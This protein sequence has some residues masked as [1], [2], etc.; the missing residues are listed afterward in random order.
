M[1]RGLLGAGPSGQ[2]F[3]GQEGGRG[4]R[5]V[6]AAVEADGSG[7][8]A[9]ASPVARVQVHD[10]LGPEGSQWQGP[11]LWLAVRVARVAQHVAKG[12]TRTDHLFENPDK[13]RWRIDVTVGQQHPAH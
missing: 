8:G 12:D 3:Y 11:T 1:G 2:W 7:E 9:L 5:T 13:G 6:Q 4:R 10:Q